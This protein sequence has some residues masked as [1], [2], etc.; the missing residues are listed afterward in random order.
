[1][2]LAPARRAETR[3]RKFSIYDDNGPIDLSTVT[4]ILMFYRT[5]GSDTWSILSTE[6]NDPMLT[7]SNPSAGEVTLTPT[8]LLW[9][10]ATTY[11]L[12]FQ[13]IASGLFAPSTDMLTIVVGE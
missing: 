10:V 9:A 4:E 3:V 12:Y 8:I 7:I 2:E 1:M 11:E 6:D 5:S 13:L